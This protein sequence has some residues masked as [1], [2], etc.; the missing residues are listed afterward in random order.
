MKRG[1]QEQSGKIRGRM[2]AIAAEVLFGIGLVILVL[3]YSIHERD[4]WMP[5]PA[6]LAAD[7]WVNFGFG[8]SWLIYLWKL[9]QREFLQRYGARFPAFES[10]FVLL[11]S[12]IAALIFGISR[13]SDIFRCGT[14]PK[15]LPAS[16]L[17]HSM[18]CRG[19]CP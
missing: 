9:L 13:L 11:V 8:G 7:F 5:R 1:T 3:L 2:L 17:L 16:R 18:V 10:W 12:G 15:A 14:L 4:P 19:A 6:V